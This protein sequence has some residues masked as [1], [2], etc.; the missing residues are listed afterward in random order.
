M[1]SIGFCV[2]AAI[3]G[4]VNLSSLRSHHDLGPVHLDES[5]SVIAFS[6]NDWLNNRIQ[7]IAAFYGTTSLTTSGSP[8]LVAS[9]PALQ[10][11]TKELHE[12]LLGVR[13]S[14]PQLPATVLELA[15]RGELEQA[16]A[17]APATHPEALRLYNEAARRDEDG[18]GLMTLFCLLWCHLRIAEFASSSGLQYVSVRSGV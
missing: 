12:V 9:G 11:V 18:E 14:E 15:D 17:I 13:Q 10:M 8:V 1:S 3:P 2:A 5:T 7:D 4:S 16:Q 6:R